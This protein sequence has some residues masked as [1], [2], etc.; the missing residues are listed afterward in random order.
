MASGLGV[1]LVGEL[2]GYFKIYTIPG[3]VT[4]AGV[5]LSLSLLVYLIVSLATRRDSS[6]PDRDVRLIIEM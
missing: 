2:L 3:G 6:P 1:T 5:A 4:V